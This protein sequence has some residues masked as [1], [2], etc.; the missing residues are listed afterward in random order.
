[1][2]RGK[3]L[4][5]DDDPDLLRLMSIRMKAAGFE[6]SAVESAEKL[7]PSYKWYVPTSSSPTCVW[8][9]WTAYSYFAPYT[10]LILLFR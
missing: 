10:I 8:M 4:L 5:V 7:W 6:V 2:T 9:A 3:T 1:M